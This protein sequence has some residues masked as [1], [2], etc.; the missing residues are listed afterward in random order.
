LEQEGVLEILD[1]LKEGD[2]LC[3]GDFIRV[4]YYLAGGQYF[5]HF[6]LCQKGTMNASEVVFKVLV[7]GH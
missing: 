5:L 3:H 1:R 6:Y 4:I 7:P 2:I